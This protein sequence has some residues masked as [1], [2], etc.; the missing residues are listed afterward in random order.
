MKGATTLIPGTRLFRKIGQISSSALF[1]ATCS[2]FINVF[3][4]V[5]VIIII[6]IIIII[7]IIIIISIIIIIIIII[8]IL[9]V[10]IYDVN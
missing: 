7:N 10:D 3:I 2:Y 6:I 8:I 1:E 5:V 9:H 4:V